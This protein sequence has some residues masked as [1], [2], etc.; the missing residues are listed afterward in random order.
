MRAHGCP[1]EISIIQI[2]AI[3]LGKQRGDLKCPGGSLRQLRTLILFYAEPPAEGLPLATV[4]H[5]HVVVEIDKPH[6]PPF[7]TGSSQSTTIPIGSKR[8]R[9]GAIWQAL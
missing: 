7:S 2:Y 1:V 9:G 6:E 8:R 4:H 3:H 5:R